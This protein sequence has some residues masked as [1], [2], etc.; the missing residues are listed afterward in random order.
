MIKHSKPWITDADRAAVDGQLA[1]GM[2]AGLDTVK[3]FERALAQRLGVSGSITTCSGTAALVLCLKTLEIGSGKDDE[4]ILPSYVCPTV[5]QAVATTGAKPVLCDSGEFWN[6]TDETIVK[7]FTPRTKAIIAVNIFGIS[8]G[9][10]S[11]KKYPYLIIEDHCQSFGLKEPLYGAAAFY[12]FYGTKCL[13]T[14]EGGAAVFN[15]SDLLSRASKLRRDNAVPG[16]L[17]D[18]QAALGLSQLSRYDQMLSRRKQIASRYLNELPKHVIHKVSAVASHSMFYRFPLCMNGDFDS[19]S[20][21]F[22]QHGINV[23]RAVSELLHRHVGQTDEDFPNAVE[24]FNTTVSIPIY[25]V[26]SDDDVGKVIDAVKAI[27]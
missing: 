24:S 17:S 6:A 10:A 9:L 7:H 25:P 13:T 14:G 11:L 4:V 15:D 8:A 26:M 23:G 27:A 12:S 22:A 18:L 16:R 19:I 21:N 3:E 1:A 20:R 2:V 5:M